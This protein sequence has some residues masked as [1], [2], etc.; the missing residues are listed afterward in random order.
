MFCFYKYHTKDN[1]MDDSYKSFECYTHMSDND[2]GCF[3]KLVEYY[4]PFL[5]NGK[6]E[7][8]TSTRFTLHDFEH[9]CVDLFKYISEV[10]LSKAAYGESGL[11]KR[12]LYILN[13]SVLFHDISLHLVDDCERSKHAQQSAE[14]L[15]KEHRDT[16]TAFA[17]QCGL[18][19]TEVDALCAIISAHS[20]EKDADGMTGVYNPEL[21]DHYPARHGDIR[22]QLLAGIL[23]LADELDITTLRVGDQRFETELK[24]KAEEYAKACSRYQTT[25]DSDIK[26]NIEKEMERLKSKAE[27]YKHWEKLHYFDEISRDNTCIVLKVRKRKIKDEIAR[28]NEGIVEKIVSDVFLKISEEFL[29]IQKVLFKPKSEH[30]TIIAVDKVEVSGVENQFQKRLEKEYQRIRNEIENG[31][32]KSEKSRFNQLIGADEIEKLISDFVDTKK[33]LLPGHFIMNSRYCAADWV[34]TPRVMENVDIYRACLDLYIENMKKT[35]L[36]DT[37]LVGMDLQGALIASTIGF[38]LGIPFTYIIPVH[39][40]KENSERDSRLNFK[41][42]RNIVLFTDVVVTTQSIDDAC[43]SYSIQ[44]SSIKAIYAV[45]YRPIKKSADVECL[46][47]K[48]TSKVY[49]INDKY[50][51]NLLDRQK[52]KEKDTE[53]CL[54]CNKQIELGGN[55]T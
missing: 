25:T 9:H 8:A 23:R 19:E 15:R 40:K 35:N 54:A 46:S 4:S 13:L 36:I 7:N 32:E 27:S 1:I 14:W 12:E 50:A 26:K 24:E 37:L 10:I 21:E 39:K 38:M 11:S 45:F 20:D 17:D 41:N 3:D 48:Y 22:A 55:R 42:E 34:D 44:Q 33:L 43:E 29:K 30:R 16:K 5:G 18:T 53:N 47:E 28:G 49:Y 6:T 2:K 51:V 52:C 31:T